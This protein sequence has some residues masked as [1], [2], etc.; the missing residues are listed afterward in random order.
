MRDGEMAILS[1]EGRGFRISR[2]SLAALTPQEVKWSPEMAEKGGYRHFMLKEIHEQPRAIQD[3]IVGRISLDSGQVFLDEANL[4]EEVLTSIDRIHIV[5]C[6]TSWH[7]AWW[8]S[9]FWR[10]WRAFPS[11]STT[12]RSSATAIRCWMSGPWSIAISQS[13]ETADTLAAVREAKAKRRA[14]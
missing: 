8:A 13:G 3:T 14:L 2:A 11:R 1:P 5:A 9:S 6:G 7:A 12:D 4:S 10:N